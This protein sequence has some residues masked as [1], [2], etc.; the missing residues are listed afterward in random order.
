[1][2]VVY[3]TDDPWTPSKH[4]ENLENVCGGCG[5]SAVERVVGLDLDCLC[6]GAQLSFRCNA[7]ST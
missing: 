6:V 4:V 5:E 3:G 1:M 7:R 2:W